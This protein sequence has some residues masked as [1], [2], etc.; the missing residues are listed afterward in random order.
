VLRLSPVELARMLV[1][2][3][4]RAGAITIEGGELVSRAGEAG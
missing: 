3:L 2:E 4:T 1:D